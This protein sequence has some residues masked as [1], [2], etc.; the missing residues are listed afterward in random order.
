MPDED[1]R[2]ALSEEGAFERKE[3]TNY[4]IGLQFRGDGRHPDRSLVDASGLRGDSI[5][6]SVL[7]ESEG[8]GESACLRHSAM[9]D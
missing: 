6:E 4:S 9:P 3:C 2:G 1:Y 7:E 8:T 5:R